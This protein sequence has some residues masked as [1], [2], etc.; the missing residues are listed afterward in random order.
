MNDR[1]KR[2]AY[3]WR[4][5]GIIVLL[6]ILWMLYRN[7]KRWWAQLTTRDQGNY[8]GQPSVASNPARQAELERM[9]QDLYTAL[10]STL[11]IG[12]TTATGREWMLEQILVL[13]DT[14]LRWVAQRYAEITEGTSL[15]QDLEDEWMPMS[16]LDERLIAKLDQLA[17]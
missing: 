14:E 6:V 13:N 7:G 15:R 8:Q 2:W 16:D 17:L 10:H 11:I 9:A 5:W 4:T 12:G 1:V 3:D